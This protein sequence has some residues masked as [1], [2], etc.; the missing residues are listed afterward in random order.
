MSDYR[1]V[2]R[3]CVDNGY[4]AIP[5]LPRSKQ[6]GYLDAS[7][8]RMPLRGWS[9]FANTDPDPTQ[10]NL[11]ASLEAGVGIVCGNVVAIDIDIV[12][13]ELAREIELHVLRITG[14][15][16]A[17]LRVGRPPKRLLVFRPEGSI[18]SQS[19]KWQAGQVSRGFEVLS[20]GKQFVAYGIHPD[21]GRPYTWEE[22]RSGGPADV[23]VD[24]LPAITAEHV[25]QMVDMLISVAGM[26][27][28]SQAVAA[29]NTGMTERPT[30]EA[31]TWHVENIPNEPHFGWQEWNRV[32]S[33][34]FNST[35]GS[36]RGYEL[37]LW[38][39]RQSPKHDEKK[40]EEKWATYSHSPMTDTG[41]GTLVNFC[42]ARGVQAPSHIRFHEEPTLQVD[43]R[44][45]AAT[46]TAQPV[47][48]TTEFTPT[49]TNDDFV[50]ALAEMRAEVEGGYVDNVVTSG[51]LSI[52]M[53][54]VEKPKPPRAMSFTPPGL[55]GEFVSWY[56]D[57]ARARV[58]EY[59]VMCAIALTSTIIGRSLQSPTGIRPAVFSILIG[60]S[61]FGKNHGRDLITKALT[62][63]GILK[64]HTLG[65][66]VSS[67]AALRNAFIRAAGE[68]DSGDA[69][70]P[71]TDGT[72]MSKILM[73]DEFGQF[74]MQHNADITSANSQS[75][76]GDL[77]SIYSAGGTI[78]SGTARAGEA[79]NDIPYPALTILGFATPNSLWAG[80]TEDV[81]RRGHVNRF[82]ICDVDEV[83]RR[84]ETD[85]R[86]YWRGEGKP[87]QTPKAVI[88]TLYALSSYCEASIRGHATAWDDY[89]R[90]VE[91][92]DEAVAFVMEIERLQDAC[93]DYARNRESIVYEP[94]GRMVENTVKIA[95]IC[96]ASRAT[97]RLVSSKALG[98]LPAADIKITRNDLE[99][100][101]EIVRYSGERF[102]HVIAKELVSNHSKMFDRLLRIVREAGED[103]IMKSAAMRRCD[104][105]K[106][107]FETVM[108][109]LIERRAVVALSVK[110]SGRPGTRYYTIENA[111]RAAK[112]GKI[113][114]MNGAHHDVTPKQK[115]H[116][117]AAEAVQ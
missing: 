56:M 102:A 106:Q 89:A 61:S 103:G 48:L 46:T 95:L 24:E 17:P 2:G 7:G 55:I 80:M 4:R 6:P 28:P 9:D 111:E 27:P 47:G 42:R 84:E 69:D 81:L 26:A 38:W 59:A 33:A 50:K 30:D 18:P 97:E 91:M 114:G 21:T 77:M 13:E 107:M 101:F 104:Y 64:R 100:A 112:A 52:R 3:R 43:L 83:R 23:P 67:G 20:T 113:E 94:F 53:T 22:D 96:A 65:S 71:E 44:A 73:S 87:K 98:V 39:S 66:N 115:K 105:S 49:V 51:N 1:S 58:P 109:T 16:D 19:W 35:G 117:P 57:T 63:C 72:S 25:E 62:E 74:W 116:H 41:F 10:V 99:W 40:F 32:L 60:Q 54:P 78:W 5:I 36:A 93:A 29:L 15:T 37:A 85:R 45:Y 31:L 68:R 79:A 70:P 82:M 88:S 75:L 108:S 92:T 14:C 110:S 34:I 86:S 11:W 76:M 8:A 90:V 12:E